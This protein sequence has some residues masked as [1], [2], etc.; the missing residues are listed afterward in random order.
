[1][2]FKD[3][4]DWRIG[5]LHDVIVGIEA[6]LKTIRERIDV[7]EGFDGLC[8]LEYADPLLGLGFVAAQAYVLGAW[9]DLNRV[10]NRDGRPPLEKY[11]CYASDPIAVRAGVT[12]IELVNAIANYF[13]H[14]VE[15]SDWPANKTTQVLSRV[16]ITKTTDFPC[17]E[18]TRLLCGELWEMI[19]LHQIVREWRTHIFS[20]LR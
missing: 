12:R 14:H 1:M 13:K 4:I 8:A 15:W 11:A 18:A 5:P 2:I 9:T 20:A 10:R 16:G 7:E 6:G 17:V 19:V 3:E